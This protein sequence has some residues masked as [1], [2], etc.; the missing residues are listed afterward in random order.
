M[1]DHGST[2]DT[3]ML[4]IFTLE[5]NVPTHP[6]IVLSNCTDTAMLGQ[7]VTLFDGNP[8]IRF[9]LVPGTEESELDL[10]ADLY[11]VKDGGSWVLSSG[12]T[13]V[14][15]LFDNSGFNPNGSEGTFEL[16]L[17]DTGNYMIVTGAEV[18]APQAAPPL[19][20]ST[21]DDIFAE[22]SHAQDTS[23]A[24]PFHIDPSVLGDGDNEIIVNDF[25]VGSDILALPD[26]MTVKDVVVDADNEFTDVIVGRHSDEIG[27]SD[28]V[29]R[30]LGVSQADLPGHEYGIEGE[31]VAENLISQLLIS[32]L[33]LE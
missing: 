4:G 27:N 21:E 10:S 31:N 12:N 18:A 1:N 16:I 28:I 20:D 8:I 23:E 32:G 19:V 6:E 13:M 15:I 14:D 22:M 5:D 11:F 25:N 3:T 33:S 7:L 9:F 17:D 30:L 24:V 2:N 29:V 26:G